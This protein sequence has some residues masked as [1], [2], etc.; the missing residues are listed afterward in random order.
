MELYKEIAKVSSKEDFEKFL[1]LL[2][3]DFKE[4]QNEWENNTVESYLEG[5]LSW[6]EDMD[7]YFENN[8]VEKPENIN[9]NF[10]AN[11]LYA[12]K[13]YE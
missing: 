9:W 13:I 5:I 3:L 1:E 4:N 10:L 12:A 7:G 2:I 8:N 6:V 11:I